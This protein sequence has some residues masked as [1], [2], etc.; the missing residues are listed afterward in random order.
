MK[1]EF[2]KRRLFPRRLDEVVKLATQPVMDKQGKLYGALLRDWKQIAGARAS[3]CKP[4]RLQF[5]SKD[6]AAATLHLE[7][8][9][10]RAPELH[11][12]TEQLIE[13][14]ARY[15][16]Y[17]AIDRIVVHASHAMSEKKP[18]P[19]ALS[20]VPQNMRDVLSRLRA[21]IVDDKRD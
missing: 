17:R 3:Y 15:F 9:A 7:V 12:E 18:E 5:A 19:A 8:S 20:D 11:Y 6:A 16:G 10:A 1:Q 2:R 13:L 14:C 21:R 4:M